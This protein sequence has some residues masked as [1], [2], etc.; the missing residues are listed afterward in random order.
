MYGSSGGD[1]EA[2]AGGVVSLAGVNAN[3]TGDAGDGGAIDVVAGRGLVLRAPLLAKGS[4]SAIGSGGGSGGAISASAGF[5][6]LRL[7]ASVLAEGADPDGDGGDIALDAAGSVF[8]LAGVT[9]SARASGGDGA[10][11]FVSISE[12]HET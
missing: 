5:G 12:V 2:G 3:A 4:G 1:F 6:D 8:V 10:G 7:E 9:I 11:G